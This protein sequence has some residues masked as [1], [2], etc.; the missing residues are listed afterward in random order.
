MDGRPQRPGTLGAW[1]ARL[2]NS[3][4]RLLLLLLL[5][6]CPGGP[7]AQDSSPADSTVDS[8]PSGPL[9]RVDPEW[10]PRDSVEFDSGES[11]DSGGGDWIEG[12]V[13]EC[14]SLGS[15]STPQGFYDAP[16]EALATLHGRSR[17]GDTV[18]MP[19]WATRI[20][21]MDGDGCGELGFHGGHFDEEGNGNYWFYATPGTLTGDWWVQDLA[22]LSVAMDGPAGR[23]H[24]VMASDLDGDG[25]LDWVLSDYGSEDSGF[26]G[27][28][29]LLSGAAKGH[30]HQADLTVLAY[31]VGKQYGFGMDYTVG[32]NDGDGQ[33]DLYAVNKLG[34]SRAY[35]FE[36]PILAPRSTDEADARIDGYAN[37]LSVESDLDGDGVVDL[38]FM[39]NPLDTESYGNVIFFSPVAGTLSVKDADA[40]IE[41]GCGA[42]TQIHAFRGG[43]DINGD[44]YDDLAMQEPECNGI[45]LRFGPVTASFSN[46][47]RDASLISPGGYSGSGLSIDQ[48]IDGDGYSDP[49]VLDTRVRDQQLGDGEYSE[50]VFLEYGPV[51]G[52]VML[53]DADAIFRTGAEAGVG[54]YKPV[55]FASTIDGDA[56]P[57]LLIGSGPAHIFLGG[58]R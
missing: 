2:R 40:F 54:W 30:H 42:V 51:S 31:E 52:E 47:D 9:V 4:L 58:V 11:G 7:P 46:D 6:G 26:L 37:K 36:G 48:D 56:F 49:L 32:D 57:D 24:D 19:F 3:P 50:F 20:A 38:V 21:D 39:S 1:Q 44:G 53:S 10:P 18:E 23:S 33:D 27:E 35:L 45:Y 25:Q 22:Y 15:P 43:G 16:T 8:G 5:V 12:D 14:G 13:Y 28:V 41:A 29:Y 17:D 34:D 55:V